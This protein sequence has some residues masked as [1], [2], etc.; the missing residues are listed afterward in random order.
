MVILA[1]PA[2]GLQA[3]DLGPLVFMEIAAWEKKSK[4]RI[5]HRTVVRE[6][7]V[8]L[9]AYTIP[10]PPPRSLPARTRPARR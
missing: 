10:K 9:V 4:A 8:V 5:L 1:T 3:F 7:N 6:S 2:D